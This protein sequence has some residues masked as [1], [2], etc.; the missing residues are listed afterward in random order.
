MI[1]IRLF[2][3]AVIRHSNKWL[4]RRYDEV[5]LVGCETLQKKVIFVH[6][7]YV[8]SSAYVMADDESSLPSSCIN[9]LRLAW[10]NEMSFAN[11][12]RIW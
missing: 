6:D 12:D 3:S 9:G 8:T 11:K 5:D 7:I 4:Q 10:R 1:N 2:Y